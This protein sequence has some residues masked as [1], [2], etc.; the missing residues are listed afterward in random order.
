MVR[1]M[2]AAIVL[3]ALIALVGAVP[4]QAAPVGKVDAGVPFSSVVYGTGCLYVL[5]VTVNSTGPVT[6]WEQAPGF[7]ARAIG[8]A[9][10]DGGIGTVRWT[11]RRIGNRILYAT[12]G[13]VTGPKVT[14]PVR[15]GYGSG[16]LCF[17]L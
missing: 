13:G 2:L 14:V 11:P 9:W 3:T 15:Q 10:A 12:Q 1:P 8:S 7:T 17:A 6:F 16:P 5:T 4:A